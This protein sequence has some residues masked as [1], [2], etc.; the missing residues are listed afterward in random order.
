MSFEI[1]AIHPNGSTF[2]VPTTIGQMSNPHKAI[3]LVRKYQ[4][5]YGPGYTFLLVPLY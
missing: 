1:K 3:R 4:D 5:S 2:V